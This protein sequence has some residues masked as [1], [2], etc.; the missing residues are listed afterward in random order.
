MTKEEMLLAANLLDIAGDEFAN[1]G[2]NDFHLAGFIPDAAARRKLVAEYEEWNSQGADF[3]PEDDYI[4][5][6]DFVLMHWM[7]K[8]LRDSPPGGG[9]SSTR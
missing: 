5:F 4:Y 6:S 1:H 8:K 9:V 7:A 3:D 2:C